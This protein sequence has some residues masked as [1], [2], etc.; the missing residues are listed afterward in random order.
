VEAG[1]KEEISGIILERST[2]FITHWVSEWCGGGK[3][4]SSQVTTG[5]YTDDKE[6]GGGDWLHDVQ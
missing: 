3:W 2:S 4:Y 1:V 5:K 6:R